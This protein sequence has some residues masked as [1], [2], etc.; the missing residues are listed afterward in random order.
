MAVAEVKWEPL[1]MQVEGIYTKPTGLFK[2]EEFVAA[3]RQV[4]NPD[5]EG[6]EF[7]VESMG[8]KVH[9]RYK[10]VWLIGDLKFHPPL[11]SDPPRN[12]GSTN[13]RCM[14]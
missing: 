14:A 8:V 4:Q 6:W 13:T 12:L 3:A 1:E 9:R 5:L 7:F 10:E 11:L 2:D